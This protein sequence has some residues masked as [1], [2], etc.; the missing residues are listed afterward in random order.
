MYYIYIYI[1][2][3]S[4]L[5]V[6]DERQAKLYTAETPLTEQSG[7]VVDMAIEKLKRYKSSGMDQIPAE[8]IETG[9]RQFAQRSV[10]Y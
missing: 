4:S 7:A 1:Y 10:N 3:I 5:R 6:N 2:D 8:V 9:S